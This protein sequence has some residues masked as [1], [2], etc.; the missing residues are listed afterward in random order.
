MN[1]LKPTEQ[2]FEEHIEKHLNSIGYKSRHFP[3]YNRSLCLIRDDLIE[4]IKTTQPE[5]WDRLEE[6]CQQVAGCG[7]GGQG[8]L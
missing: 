5:K 1:G 7:A 6:I 2:K 3:E 8:T 4:F